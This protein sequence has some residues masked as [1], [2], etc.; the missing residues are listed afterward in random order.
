MCTVKWCTLYLSLS[1]SVCFSHCKC[2]HS[3]VQCICLGEADHRAL[4]RKLQ[5][6]SANLYLCAFLCWYQ[7]YDPLSMAIPEVRPIAA[8]RSHLKPRSLPSTH[9]RMS[10]QFSGP[11]AGYRYKQRHSRDKSQSYLFSLYHKTT[12]ETRGESREGES[13]QKKGK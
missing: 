5:H 6:R 10:Q 9:R 7:R 1:L 12:Q 11:I 3:V 13:V 8:P 2:Q 4:I